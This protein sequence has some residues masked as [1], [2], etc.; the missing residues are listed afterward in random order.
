[1]R[2]SSA[3]HPTICSYYHFFFQMRTNILVPHNAELRILAS[4]V[5]RIK[6][7]LQRCFKAIWLNDRKTHQ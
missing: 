6:Q 5:S 4:R 3:A 1:L 7:W 2:T